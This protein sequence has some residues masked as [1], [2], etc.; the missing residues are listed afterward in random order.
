MTPA[1]N[2][3]PGELV[4]IFERCGEFVFDTHERI[5]CIQGTNVLKTGS[6]AEAPLVIDLTD[7]LD[8]QRP[9]T[10]LAAPRLAS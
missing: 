2:F 5:I 6:A 10:R 8:W 1:P 7:T 3:L 4:A 9:D